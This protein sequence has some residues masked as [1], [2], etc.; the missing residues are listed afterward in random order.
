MIPERFSRRFRPTASDFDQFNR[1]TARPKSPPKP[2]PPK[3][4]AQKP[5]AQ[6]PS[7]QKPSAQ[8]PSALFRSTRPPTEWHV[9]GCT[10]VEC[11]PYVPSS[12]DRLTATDIAKLGLAGAFV[13]NVIAFA[14]NPHAAAAALLACFG[15]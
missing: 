4:S 3:L 2:S 15:L 8:K 14:I 6:K 1:R 12:P 11:E 7:A 10:C 9:F 13:G 5:S